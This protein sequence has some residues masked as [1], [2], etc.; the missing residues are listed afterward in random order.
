MIE[1]DAGLLFTRTVRIFAGDRYRIVTNQP[2]MF[3]HEV[4][5]FDEDWVT[6]RD[7]AAV[8]GRAVRNKEDEKPEGVSAESFAS[9]YRRG[10]DILGRRLIETLEKK[11]EQTGHKKCLDATLFFRLIRR[12]RTPVRNCR[13]F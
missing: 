6:S 4:E 11:S 1:Q 2:R 13:F 7:D 10:Y 9:A 5:G 8:V 3:N 12:K